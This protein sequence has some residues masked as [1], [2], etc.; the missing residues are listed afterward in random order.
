MH[1]PSEMIAAHDPEWGA[2]LLGD[3]A[4][5]MIFDNTKLKRLVPG[6]SA[7][8][9]FHRGAAEI[10]AWYDA[11]PARQVIDAALDRRMDELIAAYD[12]AT[13]S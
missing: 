11:D 9:P 2:G 12:R 6:F 1:L 8:I 5:S 10:M 13:A 7:G 3:K 4:H